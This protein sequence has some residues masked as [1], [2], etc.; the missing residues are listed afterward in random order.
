ML[1]KDKLKD[2]A[3]FAY[4]ID[5]LEIMSTPGRTRLLEQPWLSTPD[6][7]QQEWDNTAAVVAAFSNADNKRLVT[8]LRHQMMELQDLRGTLRNLQGH[9]VIDEIEL[10]QVK[11]FAFHTMRAQKAALAMNINGV[12]GLPDLSPV[13]NCLDPDH[14]GVPTF[15]IYDSYH[16]G[17]ASLR[18]ALR[19]KQGTIAR[20]EAQGEARLT[21]EQRNIWQ[22]LHNDI[23]DLLLIHDK[24]QEE[25]LQSI[26]EQLFKLTDLLGE[27]MSQMAY[28]DLLQAKATQAISWQFVKPALAAEK[29]GTGSTTRYCQIINPRLQHRNQQQ[30]IRYQPIDV[31]LHSGVCLITGANMAGKT[32][33]L[34]TVGCA[35]MMAQFGMFVPARQASLVPV[36][37]VLFC[38][39]DEQNEMNGLSSFASEI[40]KISDTLKRAS[41]QHLLILIDEPARTTNPM[42]GKAIV[43]AIG[44]L[45]N[46]RSSLTLI[47][48]HYSQ[49]GIACRRLRVRGFVEDLTDAELTPESINRFMD[50]SLLPDDSEEVPQEALR[51]ASIL[52]CDAEM[53]SLAK[54][55]LNKEKEG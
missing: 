20:L 18:K 5:E 34:K 46:K 39:G 38:I 30:H 51:I 23:N 16:P 24:I 3:G 33:M 36:D 35:Q 4:I 44:T 42:E 54:E 11:Q 19:E 17:L 29:G 22:Q 55:A 25:V 27:G 7:L 6:A 13:F 15:Y 28:T 40:I 47:T 49:L 37:D 12:L 48:T 10:F 26:S 21:D 53:I 52:G 43:Q 41:S 32:V 50:Y 1:L 9:V 31:E 45:L 2:D 8:E 14:T